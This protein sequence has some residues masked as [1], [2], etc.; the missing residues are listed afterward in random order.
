MESLI[1]SEQHRWHST[2]NWNQPELKM[3]AVLSTKRVALKARWTARTQL[4]C[5]S[6][7]E[8]PL[9]GIVVQIIFRIFSVLWSSSVS[10]SFEIHFFLPSFFAFFTRDL[11]FARD[12]HFASLVPGL[13]QASAL[14][15]S[16]LRPLPVLRETT[17]HYSDRPSPQRCASKPA[18]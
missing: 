6:S 14:A 12:F 1:T 18:L 13:G 8:S 16:C 5:S 15:S 4:V 11:G 7:A 10:S 17:C 3:I 2:P 9:S